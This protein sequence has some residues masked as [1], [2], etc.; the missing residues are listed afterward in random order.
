MNHYEMRFLCKA[1]GRDPLLN[2]GGGGNA[3]GHRNGKQLCVSV[4]PDHRP[5]PSHLQQN[6]PHLACTHCLPFVARQR[7][8]PKL[9]SRVISRLSGSYVRC[10]SAFT[11]A[12]RGDQKKTGLFFTH[13]LTSLEIIIK[14]KAM[15][16]KQHIFHCDL[17]VCLIF[18]LLFVWGC[19]TRIKQLVGCLN[20]QTTDQYSKICLYS[21]ITHSHVIHLISF[22]INGNF[23]LMY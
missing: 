23:N 7:G 12:D 13:P 14:L 11:R 15:E 21:V 16:Q 8:W 6:F 20:V 19:K 18:C 17:F 4:T 3:V 5:L 9:Q 22:N 10:I 2:L 1:Q